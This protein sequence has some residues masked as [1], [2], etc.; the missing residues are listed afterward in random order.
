VGSRSPPTCAHG[1]ERARYG[2]ARSRQRA[3]VDKGGGLGRGLS[4]G[5]QMIAEVWA[6]LI[7]VVVAAALGWFSRHF[8]QDRPTRPSYWPNKR[9]G[10][11]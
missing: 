11:K 10:Y 1:R 7:A 2:G 9:K 8:Q 6:E 4:M 3:G 5:F